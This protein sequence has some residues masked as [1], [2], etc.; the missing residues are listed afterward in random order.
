MPF[1]EAEQKPLPA[2][3]DTNEA[4]DSNL[5]MVSVYGITNRR[6][7]QESI[8]PPTNSEKATTKPA[9]YFYRQDVI[10]NKNQDQ[11]TT[12]ATAKSN[13]TILS[14]ADFHRGLR[15]SM[16]AHNG[17]LGV[18]IPGV[19][20]LPGEAALSAAQIQSLS[21]EAFV[22]EDWVTTAK[23]PGLNVGIFQ[24]IDKD[25]QSS[26]DS[27]PMINASLKD[28]A[29]LYGDNNLDLVA[30]SRGSVNLARALAT[31]QRETNHSVR[32]ATFSH[33][34]IDVNDFSHSLPQFYGAARHMTIISS[35]QDRALKIST[36]RRKLEAGILSGSTDGAMI[37]PDGAIM[38]TG[39]SLGVVGLAD[40]RLVKVAQTLSPYK[41]YVSWKQETGVGIL[42]HTPEYQNIAEAITQA[43]SIDVKPRVMSFNEQTTDLAGVRFDLVTRFGH[44]V[45][46]LWR[47]LVSS[48]PELRKGNPPNLMLGN[49]LR[50]AQLENTKPP[51]NLCTRLVYNHSNNVRAGWLRY[52]LSRAN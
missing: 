51:A 3:A 5:S 24:E 18:Y 10:L 35:G 7:S 30:H 32:S 8:S 40:D 43:P 26:Y 15:E 13:V 47:D 23:E 20:N 45:P 2:S 41:D 31:L 34:D 39:N 12:E 49:P 17:R 29:N 42:R 44:S 11:A 37:L 6:L 9:V 14:E 33:S 48:S 22:V 46:L 4:V 16:K 28:L 38:K 19:R 25:Y 50:S 27:Q 21:G 1:N 36:M 52:T